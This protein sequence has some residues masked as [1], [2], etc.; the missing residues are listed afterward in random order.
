[1]IAG[2]IVAIA[3]ATDKRRRSG[4]RPQP[5]AAAVKQEFVSAE[6][7]PAPTGSTVGAMGVVALIGFLLARQLFRR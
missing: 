7:E 2:I 1:M 6:A 5:I 3:A 4:P